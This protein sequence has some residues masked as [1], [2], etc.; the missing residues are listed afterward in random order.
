MK[1]YLVILTF[2]VALINICQ[3]QST[4]KKSV[5]L[6][7]ESIKIDSLITTTIANLENPKPLE[8]DSCFLLIL[9]KRGFDEGM[10][11]CVHTLNHKETILRGDLRNNK[12]LGYFEL[13]GYLVFVYGDT[14]M[15]E[16]FTNTKSKKEFAFSKTTDLGGCGWAVFYR[17]GTFNIGV[18]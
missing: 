12:G 14:F 5:P 4:F 15:N 13:K 1:R 18:H 16:F 8:N 17:E 6:L 2:S 10:I 9:D 11:L 7:K 3:A